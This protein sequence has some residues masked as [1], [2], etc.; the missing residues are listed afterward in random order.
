MGNLKKI[1][2]GNFTFLP[3]EIPGLIVV[4]TKSFPDSRGCF[5]EA[6]KKIDFFAGGIKDEFLQENQSTS[7]R[8]V[9]RGIHFQKN[10]PQSKLVRVLSGSAF[11]V[12]I[13]LRRGSKT[14]GK[15]HAEFLSGQNKKQ[16]YMPQGFGHAIL[17]LEE[18]TVFSYKA[19]DIY[20]PDDEGGISFDDPFLN[21]SW[22]IPLNEIIL[23]E[24]DKALE[25]MKE[26]GLI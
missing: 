3:T 12:A 7:K 13:D 23:S 25:S 11:D 4:E 9:L 15:W 19:N 2:S 21:I 14:Y 17:I 24:K 26:Q 6:Y 22:P 1:H 18:D 20:H 16:L 5:S 10:Y 8:G